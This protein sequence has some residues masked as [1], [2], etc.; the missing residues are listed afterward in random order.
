[1]VALI[2]DALTLFITR[3]VGPYVSPTCPRYDLSFRDGKA[4]LSLVLFPGFGRWNHD[5]IDAV[6]LRGG[7][8]R[9]AADVIV[10][11]VVDGRELPILAVEF[12]GA[13]PAGNQAWQRNGRAYSFGKAGIPYLYVAELG[14]YEL[15]AGRVRKAARLPNPAAPFS[16]LS[17]SLT[18]RA[19]TLPVFVTSPGADTQSRRAYDGAF[20]DRELVS[21]V[22][23]AM[24][25]EDVTG[26]AEAIRLK[27]LSFIATKSRSSRAGS[28]LTEQQ[29]KDAY[30]SLHRGGALAD[31]LAGNT[32]LDWAKVTSIPLTPTARQLMMIATRLAIGLTAK[33]MP[34][35]LVPAPQRARF[36]REVMSLYEG[37]LSKGF[38][39]W[40]KRDEHLAICWVA[41]FKPRHDDARP[42]R[43][44]PPLT[45]ML[46][47]DGTDLMTVIYGPA[48]PQSW[49]LL[50]DNPRRLISENG[51]WEA[52]LGISDAFLG[53]SQ[54][55]RVRHHG[56]L[57]AHWHQAP[58]P[59]R[60]DIPEVEPKPVRLGE[61]DVDT[62]LH[63]LLGQY[64]GA[65]VFEGLC[66]PPGGDWSGI[67]L[68]TLARDRELRWLTLPRVSEDEAKRPDHV[69]QFF[70]RDE[71]PII[72][73]V[74]SKEGPATVEKAIGPR[75][76]KYVLTL[77][78]TPASIERANKDEQWSHSSLKLKKSEFRF[79]SAVAYMDLPKA[80]QKRTATHAEADLL[81]CMHF[82][83][84]DGPCAVT[85]VPSTPLGRELAAAIVKI[86]ASIAL[87]AV[88]ES[89]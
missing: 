84:A 78:D 48:K 38:C 30:G 77:L 42:D 44:L 3:V 47:G 19:P 23:G 55:D 82:E 46:V 31:Y 7:V 87:I 36:A 33:D 66:N 86:D 88:T 5:V 76:T 75:L 17:Y 14:G 28:T 6:R 39:D 29:W 27:A 85:L 15:G 40:L 21:Y 1:M 13:L 12:C 54:T 71:K 72:L 53:D 57:R 63:I 9:E 43:G 52:V 41:G 64:G 26:A 83:R 69:L 60:E 80:S 73:A 56:Y 79:A 67:S 11:R 74:E 8:L 22:R 61:Q 81:I 2:R 4:P 25:G 32:H 68:Q 16:Y 37:R 51:L 59:A 65:N 10:T 50:H 35:C 62:V 34:M 89:A 58:P 24:L 20:A 49:Q 18:S 45:R 70:G